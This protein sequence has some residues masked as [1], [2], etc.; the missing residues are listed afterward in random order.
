MDLDGGHLR[1]SSLLHVL[2]LCSH[3]YYNLPFP[4][5]DH[6]RGGHWDQLTYRARPFPRREPIAQKG[7][8]NLCK[9]TT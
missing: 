3:F 1:L 4:S 8:F 2:F 5:W 6:G 9:G 7:S